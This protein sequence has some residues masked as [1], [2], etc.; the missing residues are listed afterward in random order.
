MAWN[1]ERF[2]GASSGRN[3]KLYRYPRLA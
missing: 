2:K 3:F 1:A